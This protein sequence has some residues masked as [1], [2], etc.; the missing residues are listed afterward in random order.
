MT[1]LLRT[2]YLRALL[3]SA[4]RDVAYHE[5]RAC[6]EP[7]LAELAR[8]RVAELRVQLIDAQKKPALLR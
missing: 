5:H 1:N 4:E 2:L 8:G 7:Q 3:R 6:V